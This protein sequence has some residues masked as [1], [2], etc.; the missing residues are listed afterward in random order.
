[1]ADIADEDVGRALFKDLAGSEQLLLLALDISGKVSYANKKLLSTLSLMEAELLGKPWLSKTFLLDK[2]REKF[3]GVFRALEKGKRPDFIETDIYNKSNEKRHISW[4][5]SGVR[6]SAGN[7]VGVYFL[8]F[9]MTEFLRMQ[10]RS[11]WLSTFPEQNPNPIIETDSLGVVT[12]TN[13]AASRLFKEI[14]ALRIRHPLLA[15]IGDIA[16]QLRRENNGSLV[17]EVTVGNRR[18]QESVYANSDGRTL[19]IYCIDITDRRKFE[20]DADK[21]ARNWSATFDSLADGVSIHS[22]SFEIIEAN[23]TLCQMLGKTRNE[24][25][26]RKCYD[27]FHATKSPPSLCPL[28]KAIETRKTESAE[29]FEPKLSKWLYVSTSPVLDASGKVIYAVHAI[30]DITERKKAEEKLSISEERLNL[31]FENAPDA[32]YLADMKSRFL[33]GNKAAEEMTGYKREELKGKTFHEAGIISA[34]QM[35]A[36]MSYLAENMLGKS[37]GPIELDLKRRDGRIVPVEIRTFPVKIRDETVVL[38][39]ARDISERRH[40]ESLISKKTQEGKLI[41][42]SM[43]AMV[44]YKDTENRFITTNRLFEEVM[45]RSKEELEGRSLFDLFPRKEAEAY[46]KDDKEVIESGKPKRGIT[47]EMDTPKGRMWVQTDK[48]PLTGDNGE[49]VGIVGFSIDIT[50]RKQAEEALRQNELKYRIIADHTVDW[51]H[52]VSSEDNYLYVSP[53]CEHISGYLPEEFMADSGLLKRIIVD[54]DRKAFIEHHE[55]ALNK[56]PG[57]LEFRIVRKDGPIRWISH[58]CQ[59]VF[60]DKGDYLGVRG[61]NRDITEL[62]RAEESLKQSESLY[63]TIMEAAGE[64]IA[65][66]SKE[67][68]LLAL[69][70]VAAKS[71]G[72]KS[73]DLLGKKLREVFTK[74]DAENTKKAV[75][76]VIESRKGM[77]SESEMTVLGKKRWYRMSIQPLVEVSGKCDS[78]IIIATDLTRIKEINETVQDS[79]QYLE[80]II[81]SIADPLFVKDRQHRWTLLNDAYCSFMGY[82]REQLIGKSDRDFFP[83]KEADIFWEK[84]ELVFRTGQE[85]IN[86][87]QF[88]ASGNVTRTILTKKT[89][90]TGKNGEQYIV[91]I[92]RDITERKK[93]EEDLFMKSVLLEAQS[94]SSIDGI[95]VVDDEGETISYNRRFREMWNIPKEILDSRDDQRMIN[96]ILDQ[97]KDPKGFLNKVQY[98]YGH[99]NENSK[100]EIRFK[101]GRTVDRY[102]S[103]LTD[104]N[105]RYYGRIWYFHD[106]T[107]RKKIEETLRERE[108][109]YRLLLDNLTDM[110]IKTDASGTLMFA[111]PS[112]CETFGKTESELIGKPFMPTV[113]E[114]DRT[115]Y[116]EEMKK[117]YSPPYKCSIEHRMMTKDGWRWI[118]WSHNAVLDE[119]G[120][121]KEIVGVGRDATARKRME[122]DAT[123]KAMLLDKTTDS[124]FVYDLEGR[125]IYVNEAAYKTRGYTKEEMLSMTLDK[126]YPAEHRHVIQPRMEALVKAGRLS[127]DCVH[128]RKDGTA[129][130]IDSDASVVEVGG[131]KLIISIA[132]DATERKRIEEESMKTERLSAMWMTAGA[133]H[134]KISAPLLG[135]LGR[136]RMV[137]EKPGVQEEERTALEGIEKDVLIVIEAEEK[138]RELGFNEK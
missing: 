57:S 95:L 74:E 60:D 86:E 127:F 131:K 104:Q 96:Y 62:K 49:I 61:S 1:M 118:A 116:S 122:S 123:F 93:E 13:P 53:S 135:I 5:A 10:E 94:E 115:R 137:L 83:K 121:V 66:V 69:N 87:E 12:Y 111:S 133:L 120:V 107:E 68:A 89:L 97:L 110:I 126:L 18:Y 14:K 48:I 102:S 8:G 85:N 73:A 55:K 20:E 2:E 38:G 101:D 103:P 50:E 81:N 26:G 106:I 3:E 114:E 19:R 9:D 84:D 4:N 117:L 80:K 129:I 99:K 79:Q 88:T 91:G 41:L 138:L 63:R 15:G 130:S 46:W 108:E 17:R 113:H 75:Q 25:I 70:D 45:G 71:M 76:Q 98:L 11:M 44:F 90:Y 22:T 125:I 109:K 136:V 39:I 128:Q 64:P 47:E 32:I 77:T 58:E 54:E 40:S 27:I 78:A 51:E 100:D 72:G 33:D 56:V 31:I 36:A 35:P 30:R 7:V 23:K 124:I 105:G 34:E 43:P 24:L 6:D 28:K 65:V 37:V 67:G 16:V 134:N 59:P 92:I 132:R 112:Y 52:W 119:K 42:D 29:I 82:K 21:A